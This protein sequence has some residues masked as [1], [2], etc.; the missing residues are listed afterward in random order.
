MSSCFAYSVT[1]IVCG[2]VGKIVI[3]HKNVKKF[4]ELCNVIKTYYAVAK[5][6]IS[7]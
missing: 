2:A 7:V 5:K 1:A 6:K 4:V 3:N